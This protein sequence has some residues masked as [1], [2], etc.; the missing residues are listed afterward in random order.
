[1]IRDNRGS[2]KD[3]RKGYVRRERGEEEETK[4]EKGEERETEEKK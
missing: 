1:M 3:R 2:T 4:R